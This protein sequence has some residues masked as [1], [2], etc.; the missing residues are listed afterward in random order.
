MN[1]R[2]ETKIVIQG[3]EIKD[4]KVISYLISVDN[5]GTRYTIEGIICPSTRKVKKK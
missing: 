2:N 1:T 5:G 3:K 4:F